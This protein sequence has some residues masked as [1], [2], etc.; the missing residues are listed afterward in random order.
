MPVA[1]VER[2]FADTV[3]RAMCYP[4]RG[5]PLLPAHQLPSRAEY[6][7]QF[8]VWCA[9]KDGAVTIRDAREAE[10]GTGSFERVTS[11]PM[12]AL[13]VVNTLAFPA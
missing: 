6:N 3:F 2:V 1:A 11:T 13:D 8:H 12:H 4:H 10:M 9:G 5:H 7:S